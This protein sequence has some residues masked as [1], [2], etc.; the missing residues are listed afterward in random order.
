MEHCNMTHM[1]HRHMDYRKPP[2]L[3]KIQA[4]LHPNRTRVS[5]NNHKKNKDIAM[6]I[7]RTLL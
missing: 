3:T 2:I 4:V 7:L 1:T 6:N 5:G